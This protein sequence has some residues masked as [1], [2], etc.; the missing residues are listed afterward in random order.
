MPAKDWFQ[1]R[2]NAQGEENKYA[3]PEKGYAEPAAK[4]RKQLAYNDRMRQVEKD[5]KGLPAPS[6]LS[7]L[8]Y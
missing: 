4:L 7:K 8:P 3:E 2:A 6:R 1:G 5:T